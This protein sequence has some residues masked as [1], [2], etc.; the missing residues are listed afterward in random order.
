MD[1]VLKLTDSELQKLRIAVHTQLCEG[2]DLELLDI[3][4]KIE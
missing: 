3:E 2:E 4:K 1:K